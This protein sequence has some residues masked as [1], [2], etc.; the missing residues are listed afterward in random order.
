[1]S[2][3]GYGPIGAFGVNGQKKDKS[4]KKRRSEVNVAIR[5]CHR[6]GKKRSERREEKSS[7]CK[8]KK[9]RIKKPLC[10]TRLNQ[11]SQEREG[12]SEEVS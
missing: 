2:Y 12:G 3:L 1:M 6:S 9:R 11:I 7:G 8:R 10:L 4:P 5:P